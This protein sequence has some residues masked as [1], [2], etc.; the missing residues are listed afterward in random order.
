VGNE[1][2]GIAPLILKLG[3]VG[4]EREGIA[5]LILKLGSMGN[6]RG[7]GRC[8]TGSLWLGGWAVG[9]GTVLS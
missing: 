4:N 2:E 6:E 5:P 7:P 9:R 3:N 8:T 1:R